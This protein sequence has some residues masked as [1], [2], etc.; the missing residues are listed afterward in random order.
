MEPVATW[1]RVLG[2]ESGPQQHPGRSRGP[3]AGWTRTESAGWWQEGAGPLGWGRGRL[4]G[5][6]RAWES[7]RGS[8][9]CTGPG[10][11]QAPT[12]GLLQLQGGARPGD[13]LAPRWPSW[14]HGPPFDLGHGFRRAAV[15]SLQGLSLHPRLHPQPREEA[16]GGAGGQPAPG[17]PGQRL[18]SLSQTSPRPHEPAALP[19]AEEGVPSLSLLCGVFR[20]GRVWA[21]GKGPVTMTGVRMKR[22]A[23]SA[24]AEPFSVPSPSGGGQGGRALPG[25]QGWTSERC[26]GGFSP[27]PDAVSRHADPGCCHLP[28]GMVPTVLREQRWPAQMQL[29]LALL[30]GPSLPR[31][32]PGTQASACHPLS[33]PASLSRELHAPWRQLSCDFCPESEPGPAC[34]LTCHSLSL[35]TVTGEVLT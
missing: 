25:S 16:G 27:V 5:C 10:G 33:L 8:W 28:D 13:W 15:L 22:V 35:R 7:G 21:G 3:T 19:R 26:Q 34:S 11:A 23:R 4:W 30:P 14:S 1:S 31:L 18:Q 2:T 20:L 6:D 17:G 29:A 12:S 9:W 32:V 24:C